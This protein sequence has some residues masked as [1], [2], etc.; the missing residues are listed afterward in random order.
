MNTETLVKVR[1]ADPSPAGEPIPEGV[2]TH[3]GVLQEVRMRADAGPPK[4][5]LVRRPWFVAIAAAVVVLVV[6]G[7]LGL[8]TRVQDNPD[9]PPV[10][11]QV[12]PEDP[13]V[14]EPDAPEVPPVVDPVEPEELPEETPDGEDIPAGLESG[15]IE[16]AVGP[17][18]WIH[19]SGDVGSL[20][21]GSAGFKAIPW[22]DGFAILEPPVV[23]WGPYAPAP[24][25]SQVARAAR[26]WV[27][28]DG[29]EWRI[30]PLPVPGD[31]FDVSLTYDKG[32]Y[33][34]FA[35]HPP[36]LWRSTDGTTWEELDSGGLVPPEAAGFTWTVNLAPPISN[37]RVTVSQVEFSGS[38]PFTDFG[39]FPF[40]DFAGVP[41]V[42]GGCY[43]ILVPLALGVYEWVGSS[44]D[45]SPIAD[46]CPARVFRFEETE[47]GLRV[48]DNETGEDLGHIDGAD[49]SHIAEIANSS[50]LNHERLVIITDGDVTQTGVPWAFRHGSTLFAAGEWIYA[51]GNS[52]T[53]ALGVW[54]TNDGESWVDLGTPELPS[55]AL[56]LDFERVGEDRLVV[57]SSQQPHAAWETTD[58]L[59]WD[60]VEWPPPPEGT[61]LVP[62]E[63]G[64][65]ANNG[66][67][68]GRFDGDR[69]WML[70][71][72]TWVSLEELGMESG[73]NINVTGI[74]D[75]TFFFRADADS[76]SREMWILRLNASR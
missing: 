54:R 22:A 72:D 5:P 47:T 21:R 25:F 35:S 74:S 60:T 61:F 12:E 2:W 15:T 17:A 67:L 48:F 55:E 71:G 31:A 59:T 6:I 8:L 68:G 11:D 3:L 42:E 13:P 16:T 10:V 73:A 66:S 27:S 46:W 33:W 26:L 38:F 45:G 20:P 36:Q 65:F 56:E 44:E 14:V 28:T 7:G 49:I 51:F 69:W 40:D 76:G 34:L 64:W 23:D 9:D 58:G 43:D 4:R 29:I 52:P 57:W 30:E 63:S 32:V 50:Q 1:Q 39:A 24:A 70:T 53:G 62:L 18:T 19:V 75:T 41:D 37:G